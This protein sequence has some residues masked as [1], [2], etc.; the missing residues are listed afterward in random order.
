MQPNNNVQKTKK[1]FYKKPKFIKYIVI[2]YALIMFVSL[3]ISAVNYEADPAAET[4]Q[5]EPTNNSDQQNSLNYIQPKWEI[6][7]T[8]IVGLNYIVA[9]GYII[10]RTGD[11]GIADCNI[12]FYDRETSWAGGKGFGGRELQ[13]NERYNFTVQVEV[14]HTGLIA[15]QNIHCEDG[16]Y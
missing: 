9:T 4:F 10:N 2:P 8:E 12:E 15:K 1:P 6:T 13:P 5:S 7:D 3:G 16:V 14:D 11:A